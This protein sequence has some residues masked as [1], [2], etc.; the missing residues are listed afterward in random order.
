VTLANSADND[1]DCSLS[2]KNV[3]ARIWDLL[4]L[5]GT[6]GDINAVYATIESLVSASKTEMTITCFENS[7]RLLE[8]ALM[9]QS[10]QMANLL[11][12]RGKLFDIGL[13]T[14]GMKTAGTLHL[15]I[16]FT[17]GT[18]FDHIHYES[19]ST[20]DG[21]MHFLL[22]NNTFVIE[23]EF[24]NRCPVI[25]KEIHNNLASF[26]NMIMNDSDAQIERHMTFFKK[27]LNI[28][29]PFMTQ[30]C[31]LTTTSNVAEFEKSKNWESD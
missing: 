20:A 31:F 29:R 5:I 25:C 28:Y 24:T 19:T 9:P 30:D 22:L 12:R 7:K 10:S 1:I 27:M 8:K 16:S 11:F 17:R 14:P 4:D 18:I 6:N 23:T 15:N 21:F 3:H 26:V 13:A 2:C